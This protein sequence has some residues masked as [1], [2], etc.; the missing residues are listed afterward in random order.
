MTSGMA[1]FFALG[2]VSPICCHGG[3]QLNLAQCRTRSGDCLLGQIFRSCP[4][5]CQA[6]RR[7]IHPARLRQHVAL[8]A[9]RTLP[10]QSVTGC[11]WSA[12][13]TAGSAR[14]VFMTPTFP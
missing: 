2:P 1:Y 8:K 3:A 9:R 5:G 6:P 11:A 10:S 12:L 4:V 7:A 14:L 13:A